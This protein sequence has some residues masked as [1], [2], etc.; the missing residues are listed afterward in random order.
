MSPDLGR[1]AFRIAMFFIVMP[2]GL[3]FVVQPGSA[4]FALTVATLVIGVVFAGLV[5]LLARR[6]R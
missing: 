3:L 6:A 2:A 5:V 4:E 1:Q